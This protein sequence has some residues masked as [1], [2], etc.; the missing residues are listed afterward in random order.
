M[1]FIKIVSAKSSKIDNTFIDTKYL[2]R[3]LRDTIGLH[4]NMQIVFDVAIPENEI[5]IQNN[6]NYEAKSFELS[7]NPINGVATL[8]NPR[9]LWKNEAPNFY[10]IIPYVG[11]Y[12]SIFRNHLNPEFIDIYNKGMNNM[13]D[14]EKFIHR[15]TFIAKKDN[16]HHLL[17]ANILNPWE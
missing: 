2:F 14:K 17:T 4:D 5:F 16:N 6:F 1:T 11:L 9:R 8:V 12:E 3:F 15:K 7:H 13:Y 10:G